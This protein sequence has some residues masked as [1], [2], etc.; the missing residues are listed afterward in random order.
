MRRSI[1]SIACLVVCLA[2]CGPQGPEE[3][4]AEAPSTQSTQQEIRQTYMGIISGYPTTCHNKPA[5]NGGCD[6]AYQTY[7]VSYPC[8][9]GVHVFTYFRSGSV[10]AYRSSRWFNATTSFEALVEDVRNCHN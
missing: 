3:T 1:I 5:S 10:G 9:V 8:T 4:E 6:N 7:S 2:A